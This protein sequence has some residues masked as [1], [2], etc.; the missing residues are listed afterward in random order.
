MEDPEYKAKVI[1]RRRA[2]QAKLKAKREEETSRQRKASK[3]R[4]KG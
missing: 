2:S 3:D 4:G 1:A